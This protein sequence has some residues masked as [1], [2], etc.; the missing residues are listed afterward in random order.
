M[1][2]LFLILLLVFPIVSLSQD[3]DVLRNIARQVQSGQISQDEALKKAR[4]AGFSVSDLNKLGDTADKERGEQ[5]SRLN[6]LSEIDV[7]GA[8]SF[9]I[10][11]SQE[12]WKTKIDSITWEQWKEKQEQ[13]S[14]RKEY[15]GY[16][17]FEGSKDKYER[18]DIGSLDPNY[19]LGP[20]DEII[21]TIWGDT[22][23][24]TKQKVSRDGTIFIEQYGQI[25]ISGLTLAGLEKKLTKRLSKI[26]SGLNPST[27]NPS[28][29]LDVSLGELQS[30][31]V[32]VVGQVEEAGS[33][34]VSSYSTAFTALYKAG[35]PTLEGSLRDIRIIRNGEVISKLD[36]YN[37][38][39][40]GKMPNDVRLQ[41]N[42]VIYVP[43]RLSTIR[44]NGEVKQRAFYELKNDE[45]LQDLLQISGGI[46]I[47]ADAN[48]VQIERVAP[49]EER[50]SDSEVYKAYAE[51]FGKFED[52]KFKVNDIE[53]KDKDIVTVPSLTGKHAKDTVPGGVDYVNISGHV[54]KPGRY[55]L[56][57]DMKIKDLLLKAGGLKD[58]VYWG[59][60]Y[61]VRA[62]LIRYKDNYLDKSIIP[63]PLDK[64]MKGK[65]E[66]QNLQLRSRDS[67]IVYSSDLIHDREE[68][69]VYGEVKDTGKYELQDNMTVQDLLL[70]AG[71]FTKRAYK[72]N[73]EVYRLKGSGNEEDF[74]KFYNVDVSPD[75]L[76]NFDKID[77]F[78]LNDFDIVVVRKDPEFEPHQ[79][80]A[81]KG[82]VK[83][84]G[85]YPILEKSET[86]YDLIDRAGGL[87]DE[88]FM[89]GLKF[90]RDD[91][92]RIV[93][94]FREVLDKQAKGILL[95]DNDSIF[96][97]KHPGT[98]KIS[99][100]VR[101]PGLVQYDSKWNL[102]DYIEAAGD[103]TFDAAKRKT[104]VYYPGG[105]ARK[106]HLLGSPPV[107]EGSEIFVPEKPEREPVDITQLLTNWASIATSVATVI[108]ILNR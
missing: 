19:Q 16:E 38:L 83:F 73:V 20:G 10:D 2:K 54:Y 26:Y 45:T 31:Q 71:G 102:D 94:D 66:E 17:L 68:V 42:D 77:D 51:E 57:E 27:G 101:Q 78:K 67:I 29:F 100:S 91:T 18:V 79:I 86:F 61:K 64:L 37:F 107:K 93:G 28:T 103:Y 92:L 98:V 76:N 48:K 23:L 81:L 32:F 96:I 33:Q 22:E 74:V 8:P 30:I 59:E 44:L 21:L 82:E 50:G 40:S 9:K 95:Q 47:T 69:T 43:P 55:V 25:N 60:T 99:G 105:N 7:A 104:V 13:D 6:E 108:Y 56:T 89:P 12:K 63:I 15:F 85:K 35:G 84:P 52:G 87:T 58:S 24:R 1:K 5:R 46:K 80:I 34:F 97:P 53:L 88:A 36:V 3:I 72:Y 70:Q 62:D 4:E 106:K 90:Y 14:I 49:F 11:T 75:M 65:A 39:T 41:N